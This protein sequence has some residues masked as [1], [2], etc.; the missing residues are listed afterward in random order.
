MKL[1]YITLIASAFCV[2]I[3]SQPIGNDT[4]PTNSE[5]GV[6]FDG[7]ASILEPSSSTGIFL[8]DQPESLKTVKVT[9]EYFRRTD[10]ILYRAC[11]LLE[12]V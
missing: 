1:L 10:E 3:A 4:P 8:S 7:V 2:A 11:K 5:D 12:L 9:C 6:M